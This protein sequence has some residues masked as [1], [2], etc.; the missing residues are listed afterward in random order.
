[1]TTA[2]IDLT[3]E[4]RSEDGSRTQFYQSDEDSIGKILRLLIM[5]RLFTQPVLTLVSKRSQ[6]GPVPDH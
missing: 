6:H 1:M 5:P 4:I 3:I 2:N